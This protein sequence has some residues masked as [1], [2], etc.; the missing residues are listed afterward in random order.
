MHNSKDIV[1]Y[2]PRM[3]VRLPFI[4][5]SLASICTATILEVYRHGEFES[6]NIHWDVNHAGSTL[7]N[8]FL[9]KSATHV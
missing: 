9:V 1:V 4:S 6:A 5:D 3:L 7:S 8:V 2:T